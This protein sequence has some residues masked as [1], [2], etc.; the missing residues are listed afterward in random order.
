MVAR[1]ATIVQDSMIHTNLQQKH[2][3]EPNRSKS[4][5]PLSVI[6]HFQ[7]GRCGSLDHRQ[8]KPIANFI[9]KCYINEFFLSHNR[10]IEARF[11]HK[12]IFVP[13]F[14]TM[15]TALKTFWYRP[16]GDHI[17]G[18][19]KTKYK[20]GFFPFIHDPLCPKHGCYWAQSRLYTTSK[21][22]SLN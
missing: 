1:K 17:S 19:L 8:S 11:Q 10:H 20:T 7:V 13:V 9:T 14:G 21:G 18:F 15:P 22:I 4:N 12:T 2:R 6:D 5:H 3:I 16:I